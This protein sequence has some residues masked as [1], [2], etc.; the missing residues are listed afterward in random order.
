MA[1]EYEKE[2]REVYASMVSQWKHLFTMFVE[3]IDRDDLENSAKYRA[4]LEEVFVNTSQDACNLF[5]KVKEA[6]QKLRDLEQSAVA[7]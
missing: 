1:Y 4:T 3:A 2:H 7:G 5:L 6:E